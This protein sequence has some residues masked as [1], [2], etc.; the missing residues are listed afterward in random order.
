MSKHTFKWQGGHGFLDANVSA[1]AMKKKGDIK[2]NGVTLD[3][4][5][6]FLPDDE[7]VFDDEDL[8][9]ML[10]GNGNWVEVPNTPVRKSH[11]RKIRNVKKDIEDNSED[12]DKKEKESE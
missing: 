12:N 11:N 1:F 4:R 5:R 7:I 2:L 3:P 9:L 6:T 8:A 10:K